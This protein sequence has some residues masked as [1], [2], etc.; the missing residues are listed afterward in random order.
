MTPEENQD[1]RYKSIFDTSR[2]AMMTLEP[3]S[4]KFTSGNPATVKLFG[5]KDE[6]EFITTAPWQ[7]SPEEQPDGQPSADKAKAMI[8]K[9]MEEGS[10]FFEWTHK[11]LDGTE[12]SATVLLSRMTV[13]EKT[14]LQATVRD[15]S[16]EEKMGAD[17]EDKIAQLEKFQDMAVDR[18]GK[19]IE[20][21]QRI[22]ELE[23]GETEE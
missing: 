5:A 6:E 21:K 20:L 9:A 11:K 18:E 19:M 2:D 14:F 1:D 7:L 12:F 10:N 15:I 3:P 22:K 17:L 13:E 8:M 23:G 16:E 4:W